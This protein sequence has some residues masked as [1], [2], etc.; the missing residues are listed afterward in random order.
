M[1]T[2]MK[3]LLYLPL[4]A[5]LL[6]IFLGSP[7]VTASAA[8][9]TAYA[10]AAQPDVWFYASEDES[11]ALFLLPYTYYVKVIRRGE[12]FSYVEYLTD[13]PPYK[14][15]S[16]Y[17]RTD[18]LVFVD[19]VPARPYLRRE[20]TLSYSLP[21]SG[22]LS[23]SFSTVEKSFLYYGHRYEGTQLYYYVLSGDTFGYVPADRELEYDLN[24]D[25][26]DYLASVDAAGKAGGALS[27]AAIA[28][29]C[30]A[31]VAAVAIAVFVV[32]GKKPPVFE[33]QTEL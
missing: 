16:G 1:I 20:V 3:R 19:Y 28:V 8:E 9:E 18:K 29:I 13:E 27:P 31:C 23:G 33:E 21:Q 17:C 5:L 24:T 2:V 22:T 15:I 4:A 10:V 6:M 14:K 11:S 7:A 26:L 30:I 32:R 25:Y 12:E